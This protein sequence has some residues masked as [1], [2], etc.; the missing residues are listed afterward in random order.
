MT[1]EEILSI[2]KTMT[3]KTD[4]DELFNT[5]ILITVEEVK[6]YCNITEVPGTLVAQ[7]VVIK[8]NRLG[9]EGLSAQSFSGVSESYSDYSPDIIKQL[10]KYRRLKVM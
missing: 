5:L 3:G 6:S 9:A 8:Y 2:I 7:L 4:K 10:N 1:N